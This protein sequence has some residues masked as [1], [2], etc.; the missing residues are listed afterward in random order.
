MNRRSVLAMSTLMLLAPSL[1]VAAAPAKAVLQMIKN[2]G[3]S[4]CGTHADYLRAHGYEVEI[5]ESDALAELRAELDVP[6]ELAGCHLIRVEGYLIEG[7]VPARAIDKLLAERPQIR[8]I[9]VPGMPAGS[10]GM[11]GEKTE[12][13]DVLTIENGASRLFFSE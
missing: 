13:L 8:G 1:A 5:T 6:D 9:A 10:P 7:H 2:P 12:S 4:C 3:C 11:S